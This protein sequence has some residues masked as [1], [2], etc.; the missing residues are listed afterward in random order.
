MKLLKLFNLVIILPSLAVFACE[1]N[2]V[3]QPD[4]KLSKELILKDSL[5]IDVPKNIQHLGGLVR[6][7][8]TT[9]NEN[10]SYYVEKGQEL[11]FHTYNRTFKQWSTI[12]LNKQGNQQ[13]YGK[14]AFNLNE[15]GMLF[16]PFNNPKILKL[17]NHGIKLSEHKFFSNRNMA[18][19]SKVKKPIISVVNENIYFDLGSY[20]NLN[21]PR[22]FE[23]TYTVA[24]YDTITKILEPMIKY[25]E[26][27]LS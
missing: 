24:K 18:F 25:P 11:I 8:Y 16:I 13:V 6:P 12:R 14:G 23:K 20:V 9:T 1:N 10:F 7:T 2:N 15:D 19:D 27:Y 26:E 4:Y 17:N 21:D 3:D 22:T 5:T